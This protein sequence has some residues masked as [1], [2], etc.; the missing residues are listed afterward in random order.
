MIIDKTV[1]VDLTGCE[2]VGKIHPRI[3]EAFGFP[4]GYGHNWDAFRDFLFWEYPVTK[5][6][7]K[8]AGT[9]PS[10]FKTNLDVF[11]DIL[12]ERK[13]YCISKGTVFDYEFS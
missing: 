9:L 8:G 4:D 13:Q 10:I 7:V 12:D 1:I 3:K 5:V 2:H 11:H 6:I